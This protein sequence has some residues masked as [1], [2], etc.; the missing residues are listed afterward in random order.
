MLPEMNVKNRTTAMNK[1]S[2]DTD[3]DMNASVIRQFHQAKLAQLRLLPATS[4]TFIPQVK[5]GSVDL[6]AETIFKAQTDSVTRTKNNATEN[7]PIVQE[8]DGPTPQQK[9]FLCWRRDVRFGYIASAR[10]PVGQGNGTN[11]TFFSLTVQSN[12]FIVCS[13][14]FVNSGQ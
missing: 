2:N 11:G 5:P 1:E 6:H 8:R 14:F 4:G 3:T 7:D 12:P 9:V 13:C 10:S